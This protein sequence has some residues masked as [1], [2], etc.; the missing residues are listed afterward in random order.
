MIAHIL[1]GVINRPARDSM[2]LR[3]AINDITNKDVDLRYELLMSRLV[4]LHWERT[5]LI[6]V[7]SEYRNK[8]RTDLERDIKEAARGD[9]RDFCLRLCET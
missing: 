6:K 3:H 8:Y 7:K 1:N 4:R 2:L 9:F 5:H